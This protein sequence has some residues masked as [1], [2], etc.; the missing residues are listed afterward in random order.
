MKISWWK[1]LSIVLLAYAIIGGL[2]MPVPELPQLGETIRNLYFH[3][4]MWLSMMILFT[5]SVIY[6]I[7]YLRT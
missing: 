7:K 3:V 4:C 6:S 5:F 2:L 1:I